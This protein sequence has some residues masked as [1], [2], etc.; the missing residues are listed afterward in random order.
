MLRSRSLT[1][2][3]GVFWA[4]WLPAFGQTV[5]KR[6]DANAD[7]AV[8]TGDP[9]TTLNELFLGGAGIPCD[10]AADSNDDGVVSITDAVNTLL[11]LFV[12]NADIPVPGPDVCGEDLTEDAIGCAEYA[13]CR[14]LPSPLED[15]VRVLVDKVGILKPI[16]PTLL[17]SE[18]SRRSA[19][20]VYLETLNDD[21]FLVYESQSRA[22]ESVSFC[23]NAQDCLGAC[24]FMSLPLS[25]NLLDLSVCQSR[26]TP[27]TN[28]P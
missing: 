4:I 1:M 5:F 2:G 21:K 26:S 23:P 20:L 17:N 16:D 8:N 13:P 6:G 9:V 3:F 15:G 19:G 14:G 25:K 24:M 12:G 28:V 11:F 22:I 10:D 18:V 27:I 7:S